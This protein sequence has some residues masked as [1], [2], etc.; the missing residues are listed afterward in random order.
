[1]EN[2]KFDDWQKLDLR[3]GKILEVEDIENADKLYKLSVDVGEENPRTLVA[4]IK[5]HYNKEN[6]IGKKIIV[7]CNL[8]PVVLKGVKSE[9]MLLAAVDKQENKI[10]LLNSEKDIKIGSKIS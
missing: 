7:F 4:G 10:V 5:Q 8:E 6:L 1:M 9:G 3:I 2:I